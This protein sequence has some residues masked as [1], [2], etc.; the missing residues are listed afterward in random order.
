[1]PKKKLDETIWTLICQIDDMNGEYYS[2]LMDRLLEAG[3]KDVTYTSVYM[4]KNR[5]GTQVTVLASQDDLESIERLLL[6]ETTTF[7]IRKFP[8]E[9]RTLD[10]ILKVVESPLGPIGIKMGLL[11]GE[12]IKVTPEYESLR[13]IA[14]DRQVPLP[15]VYSQVNAWL[16]KELDHKRL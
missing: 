13:L 3:A 8:V 10:R 4:K 6:L 16:K 14:L 1:M 5:P 12:I 2:Y 15:E 11:D 7:G 9:R